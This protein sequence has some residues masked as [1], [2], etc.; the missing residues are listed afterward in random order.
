[1]SNNKMT[2][3]ILDDE[4]HIVKLLEALIPWEELDF[5]Y[6]GNAQNGIAGLDLITQKKPDIVITD[7]KMPGIDG[8]S[9]I[10]KVYETLPNTEFIILSGFSQFDYA[11]KAI[12]YNVKNYLLK[13]VNK[14]EL[15]NALEKLSKQK[16]NRAEEM[17]II[18]ESEE[19]KK[20]TLFA[21]LLLGNETNQTLVSS[22]YTLCL[23]KID[24][25]ENSLS[26]ELYKLIH[27]KIMHILKRHHLHFFVYLKEDIV[28]FLLLQNESSSDSTEALKNQLNQIYFD[29]TQINSLFPQLIFT[30]IESEYTDEKLS[31]L[32]KKLLYTLPYR[33]IHTTSR[34][35]KIESN[36]EL[37]TPPEENFEKWS[38]H[39]QKILDSMDIG[40]A[41]KAIDSFLK[42][43]NK[44]PA[45]QKEALFIQAAKIISLQIETRGQKG[46]EWFNTKLVTALRLAYSSEELE[47]RFKQLLRELFE[48]FFDAIKKDTVRPVRIADS[49]MHEHY[50]D[51][52][53][54][55]EKVAEIVGLTPTYFSTLYKKE[56]NVGFLEALTEVRIK[57][58]KDLLQNSNET[59]AKIAS[60][61]GYSDI[62]YFGKIFKKVTG[63]TPNEFRQ[64]YS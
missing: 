18:Q 4:I 40:I 38:K 45:E 6:V 29:F 23:V 7:I 47:S 51:Y 39:C 43:Y 36:A 49:Y 17:Q 61:V 53:I 30:F 11:K 10:A 21:N 58:A 34:L 35:L 8:L 33:R 3:A 50:S 22:P 28:I 24:S 12:A 55:L 46:L 15:C 13:P 41:E 14:A 59:I 2:L 25:T 9:L 60:S 5:E 52:D 48:S 1:M 27:E 54:S 20:N 26:N 62:K 32:Y 64:F 37:I 16:K 57:Q 56:T 63:I 42:R 19:Q 31:V 44:V